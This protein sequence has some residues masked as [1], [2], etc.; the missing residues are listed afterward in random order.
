MKTN[1]I[2]RI[3]IWS[4]VLVLLLGMLCLGLYRPG[5]R[6]SDKAPVE[7]VI[8]ATMPPTPIADSPD[9]V[10]ATVTATAVNVRSGPSS[11]SDVTGMVEKNDVVNIVQGEKVDGQEWLYINEPATGWIKA[12]YVDSIVNVTFHSSDGFSK[13]NS[14]ESPAVTSTAS[15]NAEIFATP[16]LEDNSVGTLKAGDTVTIGRRENVGGES[17]F[18]ITSPTTGWVMAKHFSMTATSPAVSDF[19]LDPRQIR[20]IDIEWAAGNISIEP[21]DV[22]SIQVCESAVSDPKYAM[23]WK[24]NHDKL[25]IRF[26]ENVSFSFGF[27]LNQIPEKKL[28]IL[29]PIGWE[30]D[31]LEVDAAST[32]LDV[33][34]LEIREIDFDGASGTCNFQNCVVDYLDLDTAS[35]DIYFTGSLES[36][37][38]DSASASVYAV[39]ENVPSRIDMDSMSG[40]LDLTLPSDAG[41]TVTMDALSSDFISDFEYYTRN[42]NYQRGDG[43]C[44]ITMDALSGEVYIRE[45]KTADAPAAIHHHTDA[46]TT[47]PDSCPDYTVHHT[48]PHHN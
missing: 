37:D 39:L 21:A 27:G 46:C 3:I 2:V 14:A 15:E 48:E 17:W 12:E 45:H 47:D 7:T 10:K 23:V 22:D 16:N 32:T 34:T 24:Q 18:Y 28:T 26:C 13:G 35:G 5:R 20:E 8:P 25:T 41:F 6:L 30:L 31:T 4:L 36:L 11:D 1:A 40:D 42:G 44:K 19:T 29:V 9:N 33:K 38:C 43:R